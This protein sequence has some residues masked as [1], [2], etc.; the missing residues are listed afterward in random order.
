[1]RAVGTI[2]SASKSV[3]CHP[4]LC[5]K[6]VLILKSCHF[7]SESQIILCPLWRGRLGIGNSASVPISPEAKYTAGRPQK[8]FR[9]DLNH[10]YVFWG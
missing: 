2:V 10:V 1:M 8:M 9:N 4:D 3:K 6:I 7:K 5:I